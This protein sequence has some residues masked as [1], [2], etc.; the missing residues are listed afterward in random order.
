MRTKRLYIQ[1]FVILAALALLLQLPRLQT[2]ATRSSAE[3][4]EKLKQEAVALLTQQLVLEEGSP[5][6]AIQKVVIDESSAR[7]DIRLTTAANGLEV[8]D[9]VHVFA[10][11]DGKEITRIFRETRPEFYVYASKASANT[12]Q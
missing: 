11:H 1:V 10:A 6:I 8:A 12:S 9:L 5:S 2:R 3:L 7:I 4:E